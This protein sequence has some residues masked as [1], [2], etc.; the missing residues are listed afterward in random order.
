MREPQEKEIEGHRYQVTPLPAMKALKLLP[1]I[2][3]V[4]SGP[5]MFV[6]LSEEEIER[7][8]RA[9]FSMVRRDGK[10]LLPTF[11]RDLQ[12]DMLTALALLGF[13]IAVNY[14]SFF[15]GALAP[16]EEGAP[17]SEESTT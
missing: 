17:R 9:M 14:G 15:D 5:E 11:D 13:C 16:S 2:A 10:E 6:G 12:G 1:L 8:A 7:L 3:K 4:G